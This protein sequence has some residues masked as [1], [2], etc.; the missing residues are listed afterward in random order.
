MV[1]IR[2]P[3][4][5]LLQPKKTSWSTDE[6]RKKYFTGRN[7]QVVPRTSLRTDSSSTT[8]SAE[9]FSTF[10]QAAPHLNGPKNTKKFSGGG[11]T[12]LVL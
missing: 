8:L 5:H 10:G 9:L 7:S 2:E 4:R 1:F 6:Q 12:I 11:E 3:S